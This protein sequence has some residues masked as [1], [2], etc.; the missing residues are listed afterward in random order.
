MRFTEEEVVAGNQSLS[1]G[2]SAE[3]S[4]HKHLPVLLLLFVGSGCAALI[5]EIVWLQLLQLVIG[6]SG[7]IA[8]RAAGD[9]HGRHVPGQP[10]A[11]AARL[12]ERHPLRVYALL[13]LG[14]GA[15]RPWRCSSACPTSTR[16]TSLTSALAGGILSRVD[17]RHLPAAA[18]PADGRDA[19]GDR[20]LGR[21]HAARRLLAGLLLRRQHRRRGL[22]LPAG[23]LLPAASPR[24]G[25][26][27]RTSP[28]PSM[29]SWRRSPCRW[30]ASLIEDPLPIRLGLQIGNLQCAK[31]AMPS[32][33][34]LVMR[35]S[36]LTAL[37][38]E[39]V[40]TRILSLLLGGTVYTFSIILAVFLVGPGDRQQ[41]RIG[42]RPRQPPA[43]AGAWASAS[44]S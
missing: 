34:Y 17:V 23:R 33:V 11:A 1:M 26:R 31:S 42:D 5:Y 21:G 4:L 35:L 27:P 8:W 22:R 28:W 43:A 12:P 37:G 9:L 24:H 44:C 40:W 41:H 18:H 13:E 10:A 14:I 15:Y 29:S 19:A 32:M 25:H 20:S 16:S 38:A 6:S 30:Q 36:G 2:T 3:S 7:S 39:V